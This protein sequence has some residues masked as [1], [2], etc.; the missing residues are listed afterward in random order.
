MQQHMYAHTSASMCMYTYAHL[1]MNT[2]AHKH[3][4]ILGLITSLSCNKALNN[5]QML[6][7]QCSFCCP[8]TR[9][10]NFMYRKGFSK[11]FSLSQSSR[12]ITKSKKNWTKNVF[13]PSLCLV[14][15]WLHIERKKKKKLSVIF[16]EM[17]VL[18]RWWTTG[19]T[20]PLTI[21][22]MWSRMPG[23]SHLTDKQKQPCWGSDYK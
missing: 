3:T 19:P 17:S 2:H 14:H 22:E 4:K 5:V 12:H 16:R 1:C 9:R 7:T 10:N 6:F 11:V 21:L 13:G 8:D 18:A 23:D 20:G 15:L